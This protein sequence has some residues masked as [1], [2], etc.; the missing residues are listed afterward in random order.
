MHQRGERALNPQPPWAHR[1]GG[2]VEVLPFT[3]SICFSY[4]RGHATFFSSSARGGRVSPNVILARPVR[5]GTGGRGW[6]EGSPLQP[7]FVLVSSGW[8]PWLVVKDGPAGG[9]E[10]RQPPQRRGGP[11]HGVGSR[12]LRTLDLDPPPR[13]RDKCCSPPPTCPWGPLPNYSLSG[14]E[15]KEKHWEGVRVK[16]I[17]SK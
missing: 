17:Q 3:L 2:L 13:Q 14:A 12:P 11:A 16:L 1:G 5:E 15:R 9:L 10:G 8:I 6:G 4:E 7:T